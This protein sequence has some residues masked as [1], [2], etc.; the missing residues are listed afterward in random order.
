MLVGGMPQAV[1][2]YIETYDLSKVD[3]IKR[4][5][6]ELYEDDF[7]KIDPTGKL[8]MLFDAI[9]SQLTSNASR[10]QVSSVIKGNR[11][12]DI[13]EQ[14]AELKDSGTVLISYHVNDPLAGMAQ[15]IDLERFKLFVA[16]TGLF[17]TLAFKDK[18]F[19]SNDIYMRLLNDKLQ[20]NLGYVYENIIAQTLASNGHKLYYHTFLNEKSHHNYE[21]DFLISDKNKICPIEVKSSNYKSHASIDAFSVKYSSRISNKYMLHTKDYSK[22]KDL[23]CLPIYMAQFM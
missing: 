4:D 23:I 19:T 11:A 7:R 10:Y 14:I 6:L 18:D 5:I 8:S 21:I 20:T 15:N 9:P 22:D 16:D 13:L 12:S 2:T 17:I 1:E 3:K